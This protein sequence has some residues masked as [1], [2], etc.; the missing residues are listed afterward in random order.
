MSIE[1]DNI[2]KYVES[3]GF[4]LFALND[5]IS[6]EIKYFISNGKRSII[7]VDIYNRRKIES[8]CKRRKIESICKRLKRRE[9]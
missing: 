6:K 7:E 4:E 9:K 8:I 2:K 1:I 3:Y 5:M